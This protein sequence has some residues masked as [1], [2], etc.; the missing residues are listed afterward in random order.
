MW[1]T[2]CLKRGSLCGVCL[3]WCGGLRG[4]VCTFYQR[5]LAHFCHAVDDKSAIV[6]LEFAGLPVLEGSVHVGIEWWI[7]HRIGLRQEA[8]PDVHFVKPAV[9]RDS[10]VLSTCKEWVLILP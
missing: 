1:R 10:K 3:H 6:T 4:V 8:G 2:S 5:R 7:S 9:S